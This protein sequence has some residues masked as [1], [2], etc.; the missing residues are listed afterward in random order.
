M[1]LGR[2]FSSKTVVVSRDDVLSTYRTLLETMEKRCTVSYTDLENDTL[3]DLGTAMIQRAELPPMQYVREKYKGVVEEGEEGA[4]AA[5]DEAALAELHAWGTQYVSLL[6][7][8]M[9]YEVELK[10][11]GWGV[12]DRQP[13]PKFAQLDPGTCCVYVCACVC[14]SVV[15]YNIV[16][17]NMYIYIIPTH[18]P[19]RR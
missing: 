13:I 7:S 16:Y 4:A 6:A 5:L 14:V 10:A 12:P 18:I 8:T 3:S 19:Y 17:G 9:A 2:C 15:T 1:V 11:S